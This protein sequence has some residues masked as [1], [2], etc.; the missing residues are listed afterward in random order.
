MVSILALVALIAGAAVPQGALAVPAAQA[1]AAVSTLIVK[2]RPGVTSDQQQAAV[3]RNGGSVR[4]A[5]PQLGMVVVAVPSAEASNSTRRYQADAQVLRVDAD[6]SRKAAAVPNDTAYADQWALP[7]IG[8]DS[9][10]GTVDPAGSAVVA[11]LDTG[12][13]PSVADLAGR[14]VAGHSPMAGADPNADVN[15]HGTRLAT[16]A[17]AAAGNDAAI[18]GVGFASGVKVMPVK[19]L[20]S[21]GLGQDSDVIAGVVWA[22]DNGASVILMGFSAPEFSQSLQDAVDYAWA[23]GAVLVAATG[24]DGSTQPAYPAGDAK[25]V[26]VSATDQHDVLWSGSNH[27]AAAFLAA[28]GVDIVA[29]TPGGG[30]ASVTGT[31]ASA[32]VVAGAAALLRANDPAASPGTIVGRLARNADVA[33]TAEQTGNGRVNLARSIADTSTDEVVPAGAAPLGE[34][35]PFVGPYVIA[36]A[37]VNSATLNGASSVTVTTGASITAAVSVTSGNGSN[38]RAGSI[39]WRIATTPPGTVTCVDITDHNGATKTDTFTITAPS[40]TGTYNAYF[41]AYSDN[42]CSQNASNV[43]TLSNAVNVGNPVPTTSGISPASKA[44]GDDGFTLTVSGSNFVSGSVVRFAGSDRATTFVSSTQLTAAIPATD[45]TTLGDF[46]IRV[47][48]PTPGGGL[49]NPQTFSVKRG[50]STSV[51]CSPSSLSAGG[52]TTCTATVTDTSGAGATAPDGTVSFST[53]GGGSFA[54]TSCTLGSPSGTSKSCSVTYNTTSGGSQTITATYA[55]SATHAVSSGTTPLDVLATCSTF[56]ANSGLEGQSKGSAVWQTTNLQNWNELEEIP[57]RVRFCG[58]ASNQQITVH[59]P[60]TKTTGGTRLNGVDNLIKFTPSSGVTMTDLVGSFPANSD[61][62]SYTFKVTKPGSTGGFVEFRTVLSADAHNFGGSSL[63]LSGEPS[64]MGNLQIQKPGVAPGTPDL[65]VTKSGP[66]SAAPGSTITYTLDYQNKAGA[67]STATGIQLKDLLPTSGVTY[68]AGSC[69]DCTVTGT[70]LTWNLGSLSP[71]QAGQKT[72]QV[73]VDPNA[74]N[75]STFT[76]KAQIRSAENDAT[77]ADNDAELTTTVTVVATASISGTVYNDA[78]GNGSLDAGEAGIAGVTVT[79]S[80]SSTAATTDANGNYSFTGLLAGEYTIDY[81]VPSGHANTGTKPRVVTVGTGA[82]STGNHFFARRTTSTALALMA[83]TNP[84]TYGDPVTFTATVTS[85]AGDPSSVGTVTFRNGS[86]VLCSDVALSGNTASCSPNLSASAAAYSITAEYSGTSAAGGYSGSTS[87]ALSHTVNPRP[88][89]VTADAKSKTYGEADPALTYQVTS[90]SLVAGDAFTGGLS[91]TAGENVGPYA[92]EQ[93]TLA[94]NANYVLTF[95]GANLTINA[96]PITVTA[97]AKEKVYG[98]DDPAL[99]YQVTSGSLA[100]SDAFTGA[101]TRVAGETVGSY[102]IQQGTLALNSNYALTYVPADLM[103][104]KAPSTVTVTCEPTSLTYT[105]AALEPCSAVATG[106]GMDPVALNVTYENNTNAGTATASA[107]W[108]GDANHTGST[109]SASFEITPAGSG[110]VVDAK[111]STYSEQA[112]D[113][114]FTATVSNTSTAAPVNEG[115]VTFAVKQGATTLAAGTSATV[116][117]GAASKVLSLPAGTAAG[118]YTIEAAYNPGPN[119]NPSSGSSTLTVGERA[120]TTT[121][122]AAGATFGDASVTLNATVAATP[123][124]SSTVNAGTVTFTVKN[125]GGTL[126]GTATTS[127]TVNNGNASVS[128]ALPTGLAAGSYTIEAT[129]NPSTNFLTSSATGANA[130]TLTIGARATSVSVSASVNPVQ[131]SDT[132][133]LT[134]TVTPASAG[135]QDVAGSVQF[136]VNG[137]PVGTAP[138]VVSSGTAAAATLAH[139]VARPAGSYPL[140]AGFTST[141]ANFAGSNTDSQSPAPTL[142]VEHEKMELEYTGQTFVATNKVGGTASI[143]VSARVVEDQDGSL[144]TIPWNDAAIN[145]RVKF[146]VYSGS[147]PTSTDPNCTVTVSQGSGGTGTAGCSF[148]NLKEGVYT[149]HVELI[150]NNHYDADH[151]DVAVNVVDPGTGFTTGGGWINDPNTGKRSNFG[152]TAK[153]LKNGSVQGNSLFIYRQD[154][155]LFAM[156]ITT[157]PNQVRAYNFWVKSNAMDALQQ[158][159]SDSV[160]TEPCWATIT[161]K[162]NVKAIDRDTGKEYTLGADILG[163][164]QMFQVD[165]TDTGEPGSK[166][167]TTPDGYAIRVWTSNGTVY[168][169]GTARTSF[170]GTPNGTQVPLAGGNVQVR[171]KK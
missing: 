142:V 154:A 116:A 120:T 95:A 1:P 81:T 115:T 45:L 25:V 6:H 10:Y 167:A 41:V 135:G 141:N 31:S 90:G 79:R 170:E 101:L 75:N 64:N 153:F 97:D 11:V 77:P 85:D 2:F 140:K 134:A 78:N 56:S 147:T 156:G 92:I 87:S 131:Y 107:T 23:K 33:G 98:A 49:S 63:Q 99:T 48:N 128:Y 44:R 151:E 69:G 91:R 37:T 51:A 152:I 103:I 145:L 117:A 36:A 42:G 114:T 93:G 16:I 39:G 102:Q 155:N 80:G 9:V 123:A 124:G 164:Q 15:G 35:G 100:F 19:V 73:T 50:T 22:A 12:V 165:V 146:T 127:G 72:L 89:T 139:T 32:A 28:P 110:L 158:K 43:L 7:K 162:S 62:W 76:N 5:V 82:S 149:V 40:A 26:G 109:N 34:G 68:V 144:G 150:A 166:T 38:N 168:Q 67:A 58:P 66:T 59:F 18:A 14:T 20:D 8:W 125:G 157:A 111:T 54:A 27:G 29:G 60:H 129:Y 57:T 21:E 17:A 52:S 169:V 133:T 3:Q 161:G 136:W 96:R 159:C 46:E 132:T 61:T 55:G 171:L 74:A 148:S 143:A 130:A 122:Q 113:V 126:M 160:G 84:S 138:V 108:A 70:E 71:G 163:N 105:G 13:D 118:S 4:R 24:N 94:L 88:V 121:A 83:G 47:F 112:V 86:T 106:A 137:T 30:T 104:K 53:S 119:F 65:V